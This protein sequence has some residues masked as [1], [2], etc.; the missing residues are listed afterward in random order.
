MT[1]KNAWPGHLL[2]LCFLVVA[3]V[4][5]RADSGLVKDMVRLDQ[6]YIPV[7]ALTSDEKVAGSRKAMDALRPVW[8]AFHK[9]HRGGMPGDP[10]WRADFDK[11]DGYIQAADKII[12]SGVNVK[13]AHEELEHV[14]LVF[15]DLR[16]RNHITYYIDHLTRFHEPMEKIVLA[17]KGKTEA[18]LTDK[19]IDTIRKA[20][21]HA[22]ELWGATLHA[23]FDAQ[24]YGFD[25]K[26]AHTLKALVKK[27]QAVLVS[28]DKAVTSGN[29]KDIIQA[30]LAIKPNFAKMFK[31]FGRFP[32]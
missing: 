20:L 23:R 3:A 31:L 12:Q 18:T 24:V 22:F 6:V 14:R 19:D 7:L 10:Q 16:Q 11:V 29:R 26:Q 21:P 27:E 2:L 17:A 32:Q 15:L 1:Y 13:Q 4:I 5:A 25:R 28:L 8:Q 30:A 9:Q